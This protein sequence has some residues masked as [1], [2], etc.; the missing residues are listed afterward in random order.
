MSP[1]LRFDAR[2]DYLRV[3]HSLRNFA[4]ARRGHVKTWRTDV[5]ARIIGELGLDKVMLEAADP[6]V[7]EWYIRN[8]GNEVNLFVDH[9]QIV[10]LEALRAKPMLG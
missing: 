8:Y 6:P 4:R 9:S 2:L 7:F 1:A 10:R 5:V 3:P